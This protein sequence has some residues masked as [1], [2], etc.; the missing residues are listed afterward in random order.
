MLANPLRLKDP[1]TT[2]TMLAE[3]ELVNVPPLKVFTLA[4]PVTLN[5]PP[6]TTPTVALF[7]TAVTPPLSV[8]DKRVPAFTDPPLIVLTVSKPCNALSV[9]AFIPA[10]SSVASAPK[11]VVPTP[12]K[13]PNVMV[14]LVPV[15]C[16]SP[17]LF[18]FP[19]APPFTENEAAPDPMFS[20]T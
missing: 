18:T 8:P 2:V 6:D 3:L 11:L 17:E 13:L 19:S 14:P 5:E 9:P 4:V 1:P 7:V 10:P 16:S 20:T 12:L 15:N